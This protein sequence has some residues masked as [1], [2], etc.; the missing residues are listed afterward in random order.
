[1]PAVVRLSGAAGAS[2]AAGGAAGGGLVL[3]V[4]RRRP[5][6]LYTRVFT[7]FQDLDTL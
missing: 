1:M 6:L 2:G 5:S 7:C 4:S 3:V